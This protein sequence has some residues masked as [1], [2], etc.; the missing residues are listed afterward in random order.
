M[1][2]RDFEEFI[3]QLSMELHRDIEIVKKM[4]VKSIMDLR[5]SK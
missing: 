1:K 3:H 4:K 2:L 5:V